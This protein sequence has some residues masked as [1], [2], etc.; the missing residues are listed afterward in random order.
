MSGTVRQLACG[1][2]CVIGCLAFAV[3][4]YADEQQ[5]EQQTIPA[6]GNEGPVPLTSYQG[7]PATA[8]TIAAQRAAASNLPVGD[9]ADGSLMTEHAGDKLMARFPEQFGPVEYSLYHY[10][11]AEPPK[12]MHPSLF[13]RGQDLYADLGLYQIIEN[14]VYQIRG[15]VAGLTFVR[16]HSGWILLDAG[17]TREFAARSW[18]FAQAHLPGGDAVDVSAVVYSHSHGDHFGGVKGVI[19]QDDVDAGKVEVIAPHGFVS[20]LVSETILAGSAGE[21]RGAYHFGL[22]LDV[23]P[24]G[25]EFALAG[26]G[27]K[28]E[29][30]EVSLIAPT[31][32]LPSG[33]GEVTT[34]TVD[35]VSIQFMDI[36]GL[37]APAATAMYI[38][39]HR[40]IFNAELTTRKLHNVYTLR[41]AKT[42]DALGWSKMINR[43][44]HKWGQTAEVMTGPHGPTFQGNAR[45]REFLRVQ[46]DMYGFLHNQS[47]R[48]MNSGVKI[49]DIGR[50][51]EALVPKSLS[52][53]WHTRGYHGTYNHNARA[54]VNHYIGYYDGNP[55]SLNPLK[56]KP[57]AQKYVEYMGGAKSILEKAQADFDRG[58]Y[59]FVATVLDKL[60]TA[61]PDHWPARHLLA[62]AY[63]QLGYQA[64][65][66]QFRHAYLSAAKELRVG[67][68]LQAGLGTS[69]RDIL[70]SASFE[71][72]LD[73]L[74]VHIDAEKADDLAVSLNIEVSNSEQ[75]FAAEL[76][77]SNFSYAPV[78]EFPE[79]DATLRIAKEQLVG[80]AAGGLRLSDLLQAGSVSVEGDIDRV[81]ALFDCVVPDNRAFAIVPTPRFTVK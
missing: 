23:K 19:S 49:Q 31:I 60:V 4:V 5:D 55:A 8:A 73:I 24:D 67:K 59:T 32:E 33:R 40:L 63:E 13:A 2:C 25:S 6:Y 78:D 62:D 46:R 12:T 51:V 68:V 71:D 64:E 11:E 79:A 21:R 14:E 38:L 75:K 52:S 56:I 27:L 58:E 70:Q 37:E 47:V 43:I 36:S 57:E 20:A 15:D 45:I 7:K 44:L 48:L 17:L 81:H 16:G 29:A 80:V 41:G 54:V 72:V 9:F 74:A 61:E 65:G 28:M 53:L 50:E 35:G 10:F 1:L 66:P 76:A 18:A 3:G 39:K 77:H 42:R 30:G 34:L 69:A 26:D 22:L